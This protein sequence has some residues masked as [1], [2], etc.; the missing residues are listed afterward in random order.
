MPYRAWPCCAPLG[1]SYDWYRQE[2]KE[3]AKLEKG[4]RW[5]AH[6]LFKERV[7]REVRQGGRMALIVELAIPGL[8][9]VKATVVATHLENKC[10]PACR[11]RQMEA[12][13]ADLKEDK[14]PVVIAGDLNTT[15]KNSTP[16]SLRNEIMSRVT[17]YQFWIRQTV[18]YFHP[19]GIYKRAPSPLHYF[20]GY[21]DPTAFHLPILWANRE[22][23]LFAAV[24]KF[25][26]ADEG[27]FDFRGDPE[28]TPIRRSRTLANTNARASKGFFPTYAFSRDYAGLVGRF[29]L[30]WF[31]VKPF[32]QG[33]RLKGQS[34][35]FAPHFPETMRELNE[36][37][38]ERISDHP[39]MTVDLPL[40]EPKETPKP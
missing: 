27:A 17:D 7:G 14:N 6:K 37:V 38:A 9:T 35:L 3:T 28:R 13:L 36:S 21:N 4:K 39:P 2:A 12:L 18:S 40:S 31:L 15:S 22:R 23:R 34:Y 20:H 1:R 24:E 30:D 33:P 26:F 5:A 19:L 8:P 10:P 25:R 16:V 29:K 11:C 32:I